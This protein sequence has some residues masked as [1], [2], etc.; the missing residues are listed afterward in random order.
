MDFFVE[1]DFEG[2]EYK[3]CYIPLNIHQIC[4]CDISF[5]EFKRI[6]E[7]GKEFINVV[8]YDDG[9]PLQILIN[10][11]KFLSLDKFKFLVDNGLS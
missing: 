5:D 4:K 6:V 3:L 8:C 1:K 11:P 10:N 9:T 2:R 7:I